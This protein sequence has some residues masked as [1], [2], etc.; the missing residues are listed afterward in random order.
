MFLNPTSLKTF[1]FVIA[2]RATNLPDSNLKLTVRLVL[3][4]VCTYIDISIDK[5]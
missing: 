5:D 2:T 3:I 4:I 1:I